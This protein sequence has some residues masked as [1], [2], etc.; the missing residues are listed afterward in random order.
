MLGFRPRQ[1]SFESISV[2]VRPLPVLAWV[3]DGPKLREEV[4][5]AQGRAVTLSVW[6]LGI[7]A[8]FLEVDVITC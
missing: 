7:K 6:G 4:G 3:W 1:T 2:N 5:S 8:G